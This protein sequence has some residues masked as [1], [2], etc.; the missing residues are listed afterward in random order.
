MSTSTP[1]RQLDLDLSQP[2]VAL[3]ARDWLWEAFPPDKRQLLLDTY[4][5]LRQSDRPGG[6]AEVQQDGKPK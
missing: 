5:Y 2:F 4:R 3:P 1:P 6:S